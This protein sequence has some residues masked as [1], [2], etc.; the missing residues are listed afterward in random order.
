MYKTEA[1]IYKKKN[2]NLEIEEIE[3]S[4]PEENE[5]VVKIL[6]SGLCGSI[7]VNL[8]RE[9]KNPEL[10]GHEGT[11]IV[12]KVGKK[13]KH[14]KKNDYVLISWMPYGANENT[15]YLNFTNFIYKKKTYSSLIYTLAKKCKIH[16]QFV[17]KI[18]SNIS[19]RDASVIGC[20]VI[21]GYVPI[22]NNKF[23]KKES[24]LAIF[25]MGGLGLL[26][27]NA[28]KK[29]GV[30]N[31]V[32]ID[33]DNKKLKFAKKFGA[34]SILN[35]KDK[36]F[37]QKLQNF[38]HNKGFDFVFD[39]VGKKD[40]QEN[41]IKHLKKCIPGFQ[42]GGTLGMMGFHYD[43]LEFSARDL[44][45]NENTIYGIRGGSTIM[46]KD[47]PQVYKDIHSK[48]LHLHKLITNTFDFTDT[49]KAI[50]RLKA[51]KIIGRAVIKI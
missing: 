6:Y 51:G 24:S 12:C 48:K 2:Q 44:L 8:S 45:M 30:K 25:G 32:C 3:F 41:S 4:E 42:R 23:I 38:S 10:L 28:A 31:I 46:Q 16:S 35:I 43:Q 40:I 7:L 26:A 39:C 29:I 14:V 18:P 19:L 13:V 15:K 50:M 1:L 20:A 27:L 34:K 5:V 49:N 37:N 9:P 11:G 22:I 33:I 21:S 47:L 36:Y 17:S